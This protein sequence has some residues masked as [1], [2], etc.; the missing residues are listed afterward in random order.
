MP[1]LG[2]LGEL[3]ERRAGT[4][5]VMAGAETQPVRLH[6]HDLDGVVSLGVLQAILHVPDHGRVLGIGLDLD[7]YVDRVVKPGLP[8]LYNGALVP[9]AQAEALGFRIQICGSSHS[10]AF[11]AVRNALQTVKEAGQLPAVSSIEA[12]SALAPGV[13]DIRDL[14]GLPDVYEQERRYKVTS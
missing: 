3:G 8:A 11:Y 5:D 10:V 12:T 14:L 4:P 2:R 7:A 13:P 6:D 9:A 1:G